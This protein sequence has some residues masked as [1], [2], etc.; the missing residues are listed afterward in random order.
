MEVPRLGAE[1]ELQLLAYATATAISDLSRICDLHHSLQHC[2]ILNPLR[3]ARDQ[4]HILTDTKL[5]TLSHNGNSERVL[6]KAAMP[7][8]V[9][10]KCTS[11]HTGLGFGLLCT[12]YYC[13]AIPRMTVLEF[14][15][16]LIASGSTI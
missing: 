6:L 15:Q 4:T 10:S 12:L 1:S 3:E 16:E 5:G 7:T 14:C 11:T 8:S 2:L 13:Q 9:L